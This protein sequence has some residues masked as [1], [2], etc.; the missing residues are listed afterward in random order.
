MLKMVP[1][2]GGGADL[3]GVATCGRAGRRFLRSIFLVFFCEGSASEG[4]GARDVSLFV[5]VRSVEVWGGGD[6]AGEDVVA[7]SSAVESMASGTG[8]STS[9]II[10]LS[11]VEDGLVDEHSRVISET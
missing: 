1:V 4:L 2:C 7:G 11:D 10:P 5:V 8:A 3:R 6:G 9:V